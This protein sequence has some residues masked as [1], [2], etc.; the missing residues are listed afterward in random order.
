MSFTKG[1]PSRLTDRTRSMRYTREISEDSL[2]KAILTKAK[3][4]A[5]CKCPMGFTKA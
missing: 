1:L 5:K 4:E 2:C 3:A